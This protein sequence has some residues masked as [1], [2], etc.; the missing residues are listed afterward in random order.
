AES[1]GVEGG[2][3]SL[4]E[5]VQPDSPAAAAGIKRGDIIVA[6]DGKPVSSESDL[7]INVSQ[8]KPGTVIKIDFVRDGMKQEADI[9][10]G[11]LSE[12][13]KIAGENGDILLE[14]VSVRAVNDELARKY[15]LASKEGIVITNIDNASPF[16]RVL[17]VGMQIIEVNDRPVS[18]V[19]QAYKLLRKGAVN[20]LWVAFKGQ[21]AYVALRIP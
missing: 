15:E 5:G 11:N 17:A 7:R 1:F 4:I 8:K 13:D 21:A 20:R 9:T 6:L 19:A 16:G 18:N 3:G 12:N 14:G 10:L 2:H